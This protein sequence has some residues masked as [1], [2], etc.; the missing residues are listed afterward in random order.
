[1]TDLDTHRRHIATAL[2]SL[3][4]SLDRLVDALAHRP[5]WLSV[6][7]AADDRDALRRICEAYRKIDYDMEDEVNETLDC[8]GV[9]GVSSEVLTRAAQVNDAK[10]ELKR[11][12]LP[13]SRLRTRVPRK[14]T[15]D[16]GAAA[17][18]GADTEM[19]QTTRA[20]L[21]SLQ[22]SDLNLT[23]A[24]RK[25]PILGAP[26][27]TITYVR[28]STR[29]VY[30]KTIAEIETLLMTADGPAT[31]R[32][33]AR[34]AALSPREAHLALVQEHYTNIRAN[35]VYDRLDSRGRG[36]VQVVA[37][38]PLLYAHGR[39]PAPP[40]VSFPKAAN[41]TDEAQATP[42]RSRRSIL[43]RDRYL[44]SLPVYRYASRD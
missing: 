20:V 35:I 14:A 12:C 17:G 16:A 29:A 7:G 39:H 6:D 3:E 37:E 15:K 4:K 30:R 25:I 21:R 8:L 44:Q 38:L 2:Q 1:M 43:E 19:I 27:R 22:R 26:P 9:V 28:A 5:A 10:A 41:P 23:A 13:L 18:E 31:A 34:L 32:D 36:R 42:R 33:R 24:Y 40:V 11:V